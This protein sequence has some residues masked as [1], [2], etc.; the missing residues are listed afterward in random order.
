MLH[1]EFSLV[2][3]HCHQVYMRLQSQ[4]ALFD[5]EDGLHPVG[6]WSAA[7]EALPGSSHNV[8]QGQLEQEGIPEWYLL[9]LLLRMLKDTYLPTASYSLGT[10]RM[11]FYYL[12]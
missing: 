12:Q 11:H 1:L 8:W 10:Q 5:E 6:P 4:T 9:P 3:N 2:E 7:A